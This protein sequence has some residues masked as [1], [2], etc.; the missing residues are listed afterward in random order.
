MQKL[1]AWCTPY[2]PSLG[3]Q[4][5]SL[6]LNSDL[7][8]MRS[9]VWLLPIVACPCISCGWM[10][11]GSSMA[12]KM[13][14][15]ARMTDAV[16]QLWCGDL[17]SCDINSRDMLA[18]TAEWT[19]WNDLSQPCMTCHQIYTWVTIGPWSKEEF[20]G[21]HP[22]NRGIIS[23]WHSNYEDTLIGMDS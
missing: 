23:H 9:A 17:H 13:Q 5:Q 22:Q 6:P 14:R 12:I 7:F 20:S 8:C 19:V 10:C 16:G 1:L 15:L 4:W 2:W 11:K 18:L 3:S 21:L